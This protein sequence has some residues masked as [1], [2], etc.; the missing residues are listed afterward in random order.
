MQEHFVK[1]RHQGTGVG[2][3]HLRRPPSLLH[4]VVGGGVGA[5]VGGYSH[6]LAAV[7]VAKTIAQGQR[8]QTSF[9][10]RQVSELDRKTLLPLGRRE[11]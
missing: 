2:P 7:V 11:P 5:N 3:R 1:P 4:V 10:R 6:I 9:T 8:V